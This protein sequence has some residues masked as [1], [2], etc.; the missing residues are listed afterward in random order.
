MSAVETVQIKS[1]VSEDNPLG[2][3]V[4]NKTDFDEKK[5]A[6]FEP[7]EVTKKADLTVDQIKAAL[8]EKKVTIPAEVTKKADLQALLD[9]AA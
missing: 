6:I 3:V 1:E 5:H 9:A 8:A 2:Y 7:A 4:I